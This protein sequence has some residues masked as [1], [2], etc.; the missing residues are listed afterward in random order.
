MPH[1]I[2]PRRCL[3]R[4]LQQNLGHPRANRYVLHFDKCHTPPTNTTCSVSMYVPKGYYVA[5]AISR[6]NLAPWMPL[7]FNADGSLDLCIQA[8]SPGAD[9]EANWLPAPSSGQFNL[10]VR[11]FW[12]TEAGLD[13][14]YKLPPV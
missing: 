13:G 9:K 11:I 10:T 4:L 14:T 6:Y 1:S 7:K 2:H 12:P 3:L 8:T 5:N